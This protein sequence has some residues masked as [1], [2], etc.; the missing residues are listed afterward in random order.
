MNASS[1]EDPRHT[2]EAFAW[3][4]SLVGGRIV[5]KERQKRW[6]P[7]YFLDVELPS[8]EVLEL[9]LRGFRSSLS[10]GGDATSRIR[11]EMEAGV[12]KAMNQGGCAVARYYGHFPKGG[13]FLMEAMPGT[14]YLTRVEDPALQADLFRQYLDALVHLHRLDYARLDLPAALPI[15]RTQEEAATQMLKAFRR[16]YDAFQDRPPEPLIELTDW[17]LDTHR[18]RPV[19]RF[20]LCTGDIGPDQ[21]MFQGDRF[22]G[23]FDLEM[24]HVGDPMQDIGLVR[25]RDMCYPLPGLPDHLRYWAETMGRPFDRESVGYWTVASMIASALGTYSKWVCPARYAH[26]LRDVTMSQA[27][28]PI[29]MRGTCEALAEYYDVDLDPPLVPAPVDD[30]L[31]IYDDLLVGQLNEYFLQQQNDEVLEFDYRCLEAVARTVRLASAIGPALRAES[32]E[33]LSSLAGERAASE[34]D[35]LDKILQRVRQDPERDIE[36]TLRTLHRYYARREMILQPIQAF[37]GFG[38]G[39][40]MQRARFD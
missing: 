34:R 17:W 6:R 3:V 33:E 1:V 25:M 40:P 28:L 19:E 13:W 14:P 29:H 38:S 9:L 26:V 27:F 15:A 21:F 16:E 23:M 2:E 18:P 4:E 12:C 20:S 39:V 11:L 8:G 22:V 37:T 36:R 7:A 35:G 30:P 5:R 10:A 31:S 24:A 32:I